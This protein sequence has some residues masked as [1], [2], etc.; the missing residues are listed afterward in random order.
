MTDE[1]IQE[2]IDRLITDGLLEEY[3][4]G[5]YRL[6]ESAYNMKS[7]ARATCGRVDTDV[8]KS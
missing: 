4:P 5:R 2:S 3:E 1:E 8:S 6:T 7:W